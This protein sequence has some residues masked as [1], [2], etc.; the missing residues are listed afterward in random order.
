M[1]VGDA[2][3]AHEARK[4]ATTEAREL[5]AGLREKPWGQVSPSIYETGRLVAL[6]PWLTGHERRVEYLLEAQRTDGGWGAAGGYALVPT[7]SAVEALL[8]TRWIA[9]SGA[10]PKP[11]EAAH[12]GL[13]VL[14]RAMPD[15]GV[16]DLPDMPA[17]DLIAASLIEAVN[18]QLDD[19]PGWSGRRLPL[20]PGVT[21]D[22]LIKIKAGLEADVSLPDKL[23]HALEVAGAAARGAKKVRP[24]TTGAV[25][26]S[27]AAT[28]AWLDEQGVR[29]PGNPARSFLATVAEQNGGP[30]PCGIPITVFE[31]AWV[32]AA[33]ARVGIIMSAPPDL[34][35]SLEAARRPGGTPAGDGL[36]ADADTTSVALYAL[37]LLG[38]AHP[39]DSLWAYDLGTHFCTWHGE[40]G[41]SVSVNAHVLEAFGQYL[42]MSV[43]PARRYAE[44]VAK[45]SA[46]LCD[47]QRADGS[48][49]DRW[50]ASPYYA[51]GCCALALARFG[52]ASSADA[53]H[54][55]LRWILA[56]QR[57]DGSWGH[58]DGTAEET[59]YSIQTLMLTSSEKDGGARREAAERGYTY[60]LRSGDWPG[61]PSLWHDKDLYRPTAIVNAAV[62][63]AVHL[64]R[65]ATDTP[66]ARDSAI[67]K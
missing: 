45:L 1:S 44:V 16:N 46:L 39:P 28:A 38:H 15:L 42:T 20:P 57:P 31:R 23:L 12:R 55:A 10:S 61:G 3:S 64:M 18:L 11:L 25:G 47:R 34:L 60:L 63:A 51:T 30:V 7:L 37:G 66:D 53:V 62:L 8:T 52:G 35:R 32:L 5:I 14:F 24:G 59:A 33:L 54:K 40:D 56:T 26:A 22:R 2:V 65:P 48:W 9:P 13:R 21:G 17:I 6:A 58:W 19:L 43:Q 36:P 49:L 67:R 50:H 41:F 27:P 4:A 29:D